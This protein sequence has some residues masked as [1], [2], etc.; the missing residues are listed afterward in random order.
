MN[1][2]WKDSI[3]SLEECERLRILLE[4]A[5]QFFPAWLIR[6][7]EQVEGL[8]QQ[9]NWHWKS[10]STLTSSVTLGKSRPP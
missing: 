10:S 7:V 3:C 5:L 4:K 1:Q 9:R 6:D 8:R 2:G